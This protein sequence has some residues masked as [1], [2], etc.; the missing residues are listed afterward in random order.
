MNI[1]NYVSL[2]GKSYKFVQ[3]MCGLT[4]GL[5]GKDSNVRTTEPEVSLENSENLQQFE[6]FAE[7]IARI[8]DRMVA[9]QILAERVKELGEQIV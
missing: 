2:L 8:Q 3:K 4:F 6:M 5:P 9:R 1:T 7:V